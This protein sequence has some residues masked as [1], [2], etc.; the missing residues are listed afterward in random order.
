MFAVIHQAFH[1][2]LL[3][4]YIFILKNSSP[5]IGRENYFKNLLQ[6]KRKEKKVDL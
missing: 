6:K 1:F 2:E 5:L 4:A 3:S